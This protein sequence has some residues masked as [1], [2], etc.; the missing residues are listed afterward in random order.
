MMEGSVFYIADVTRDVWTI[1][2]MTGWEKKKQQ[3]QQLK[4][5]KWRFTRRTKV[6]LKVTANY[7]ERN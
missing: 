2:R 4:K 1:T 6:G 3:Q 7:D 5:K